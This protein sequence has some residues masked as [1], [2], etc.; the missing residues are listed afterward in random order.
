MKLSPTIDEL[1]RAVPSNL[2]H[3]I[4]IRSN[5]LAQHL[6]LHASDIERDMLYGINLY[7]EYIQQRIFNNEPT[8]TTN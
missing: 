4:E 2:L 5:Y 3:D 1:K 6:G 7:I 8:Q